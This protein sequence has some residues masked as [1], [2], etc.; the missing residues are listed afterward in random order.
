MYRSSYRWD[1]AQKYGYE[2][3]AGVVVTNVEQGSL[4]GQAGVQPGNLII[5]ANR[6]PVT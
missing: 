4:A 5:S 6:K 1:K 3:D 2:E